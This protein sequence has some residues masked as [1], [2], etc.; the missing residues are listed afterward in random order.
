MSDWTPQRKK[1]LY[2]LLEDVLVV[3]QDDYILGT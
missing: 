2:D 3:V 1:I